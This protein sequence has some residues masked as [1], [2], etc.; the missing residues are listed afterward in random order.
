[1]EITAWIILFSLVIAALIT[2]GSS[3]RCSLCGASSET[4]DNACVHRPPL[5]EPC[6]PCVATKPDGTCIRG[7]ENKYC[8]TMAKYDANGT[9]VR[10]TRDC[11]PIWV[12]DMQDY[13][14]PGTHTSTDVV[15]TNN[16]LEHS[17]TRKQDVRVCYW[18][19]DTDGCNGANSKYISNCLFMF[20]LIS[21]LM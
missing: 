6:L 4:L 5:P 9:L 8:M 14:E 13:C 16:G 17:T 21:F 1:M 2:T 3:I 11:S 12:S 19:C 20:L 18:T 15:V 10:L 7:T